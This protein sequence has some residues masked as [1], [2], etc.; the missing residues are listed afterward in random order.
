MSEEDLETPR[1][2]EEVPLPGGDFQLFTARLSVQG[3]LALGLMENPLTGQATVNLPH[4]RMLLDDLR[5]LSEKT[6]GNLVLDEAD[7]LH[8]IISDLEF[9]LGRV[10]AEQ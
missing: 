10:E 1:T 4:A 8:K 3:L 6:S 5:M 7:Q 2:A 9:H